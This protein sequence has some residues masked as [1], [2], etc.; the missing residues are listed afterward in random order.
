ML[1]D[2]L[3]LSPFLLSGTFPSIHLDFSLACLMALYFM[4]SVLQEERKKKKRQGKKGYMETLSPEDL[5]YVA[6]R[7]KCLM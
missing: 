7:N 1:L 2:P 4:V 3:S 6:T 5:G